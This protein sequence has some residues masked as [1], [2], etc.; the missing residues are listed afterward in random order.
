MQVLPFGVF[1]K[2]RSRDGCRRH[3]IAD[4]ALDVASVECDL[5]VVGNIQNV[6][7]FIG[8]LGSNYQHSDEIKTYAVGGTIVLE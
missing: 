7:D 1:S 5:E 6:G 4:F 3:K 2:N 8:R